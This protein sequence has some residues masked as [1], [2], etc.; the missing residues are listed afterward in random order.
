MQATHASWLRSPLSRMVRARSSVRAWRQG[1]PGPR[2]RVLLTG[3]AG[4]IGGVLRAGLADTHDV[5][6]LDRARG[7]GAE[8]VVDMRKLRRVER[9][10]EGM[11]FIV[12]LAANSDVS[13][14]WESVLRN[15]VAATLNCLEA[16]R[17][18]GVTRVVFAS[19]NH[20]VGLYER[21]EPYA[22]VVAGEYAGL[23]PEQLPRLTSRAPI[24]PDSAYGVGKAFGEAAA[25]FYAEEHGLSVLCLRIGTVNHGDRPTHVR[26][27][28]T[29]LSHR[30]LVQL[31]ARCIEAPASVDFGIFYGVSRNTWR[32]WDIEEARGAI[33]YDPADDTERWR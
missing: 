12:D 13:A 30:D 7:S 18:A 19:S 17:R 10:V 23:D 14:S 1:P 24:R 31:F 11:D 25:R 6:G 22:S 2:P 3:S 4:L 32:L 20:V 28:A 26:Q 5:E 9:A 33:G 8:W 16:A 21:D 15:N 29:L 27:F